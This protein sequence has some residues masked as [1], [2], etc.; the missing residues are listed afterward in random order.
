MRGAG[1]NF[2]IVASFALN[3]YPAEAQT[4][5]YKNYVLTGDQLEPLFQELDKFQHNGSTSK[6]MAGNFGVYTMN[7][8]VSQTEVSRRSVIRPPPALAMTI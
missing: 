5:Y 7:T 8:N 3:I 6:L 1:H 2:D 4:W